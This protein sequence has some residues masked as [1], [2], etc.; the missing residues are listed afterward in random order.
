M[1]FEYV[2]LLATVDSMTLRVTE[3]LEVE[4]TCIGLGTQLCKA[5]EL[6]IELIIRDQESVSFIPVETNTRAVCWSSYIYKIIL[7]FSLGLQT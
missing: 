3:S 7:A 6:R 2:D 5:P 4:G 1:E